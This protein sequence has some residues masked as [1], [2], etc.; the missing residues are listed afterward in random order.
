MRT[1]LAVSEAD[2]I[3]QI[4]PVAFELQYIDQSVADQKAA[5]P[6]V[7]QPGSGAGEVREHG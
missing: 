1:S 7:Y 3:G 6:R 4:S 5:L 2:A